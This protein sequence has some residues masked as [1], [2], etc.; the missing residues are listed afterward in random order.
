MLFFAVALMVAVALA[1]PALAQQAPIKWKAK[2]LVECPGRPQKTFEVFCKR[3]KVLTNG[4][5][6]I[7]P[8]PAG[9]IVPTNETL[10]ALQ[11]T[12]CRRST[13]G[14]GYASGRNPALRGPV[15][16]NFRLPIPLGAGCVHA[17]R[18][19]ASS[20]LARAHKPLARL[21]TVGVMTWGCRILAV[22]EAH[23]QHG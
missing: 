19:A 4:R 13:C 2:N 17:L 16:L 6:E 8:Y 20:P 5:L 22:Q 15:R 3:V 7:E 9:A 1:A 23:P 11:E 14:P 10:T 21:Y 12:C 18:R